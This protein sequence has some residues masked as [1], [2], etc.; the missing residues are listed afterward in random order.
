MDHDAVAIVNASATQQLKQQ[1]DAT[2]N[3]ENAS[4]HQEVGALRPWRERKEMHRKDRHD[5]ARST[6]RPLLETQCRRG[7]CFTATTVRIN[8]V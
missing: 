4:V 6:N 2:L 7:R 8:D 5:Q 3:A 1:M